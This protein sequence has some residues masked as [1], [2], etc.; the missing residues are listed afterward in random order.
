[1]MDDFRYYERA[2]TYCYAISLITS[3]IS[4][5]F[6]LPHSGAVFYFRN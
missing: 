3:I 1:M 5:V 4:I 6:R 2:D